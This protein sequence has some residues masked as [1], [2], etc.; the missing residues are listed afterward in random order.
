MDCARG[1][2]RARFRVDRS[3]AGYAVSRLPMSVHGQ[4]FDCNHNVGGLNDRVDLFALG[5]LQM[6]SG[7][8][9]D[10]RYYFSATGE[11]YNHLCVAG[12]RGRHT[13]L[14]SCLRSND[15]ESLVPTPSGLYP[16]H[17]SVP[18]WPPLWLRGCRWR[19]LVGERPSSLPA[20][21]Q[22]D[23][24]NARHRCQCHITPERYC[25]NSWWLRW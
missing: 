15:T 24:D 25:G 23:C 1:F 3:T 10:H 12:S 6:L 8:L 19:S 4:L 16:P 2:G 21:N 11:S 13:F 17:I 18:L 9:G 7:F 20:A 14:D 22:P 5:Q